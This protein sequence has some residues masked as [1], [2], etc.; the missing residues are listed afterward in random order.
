LEN[1]PSIHILG[2]FDILDFFTKFGE[3]SNHSPSI[4]SMDGFEM[5][6]FYKILHM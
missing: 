5:F 4:L 2:E 6:G 3:F 1:S